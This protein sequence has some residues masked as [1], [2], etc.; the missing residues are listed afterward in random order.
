MNETIIN[1]LAQMRALMS[2]GGVQAVIVPQADP[3]QGEYLAPHW[4]VRR[5]LSGFTGS[6][7][8]LVV[9]SD[10]A[11]LWTDS[12]YFI[13]AAAQLEGTG[14]ELMKDGLAETLS[15]AEFLCSE[16]T[17]GD[18]AALDGMLFTEASV[19]AL[20]SRLD[21]AGIGLV[22]DF[23][24]IDRI[25]LDRPALP[26]G[27][28]FVHDIKY[29]GCETVKKIADILA[30]AEKK[31]AQGVFVAML[32]EV[33]WILNI[34][35][36]DVNHTPVATAF[37]YLSAGSS[38]LFIDS[39]KLTTETQEYLASQGVSTRE[40][41]D[42]K[43]FLASLPQQ[44]VLVDAAHTAKELL[45]ILG[46]KAVD[47]GTS[48]A[49]VM[50][51][52]KNEVQLEGVRA[53]MLRDGVAM[54]RSLMEIENRMAK[55]VK[56]TELDIAEILRRH[57]SAGELYFD[58]SFGTIAGYG[59]H[60]AIV[61]YEA[62]EVSSST[63]EPHGL[64]LIDSGAQYL[65]GT[66]DITRTIA[67]GEPTAQERADFTLVM[68]GHIAIAT[69]VFPFGTRGAQLDALARQFL[70]KHGLSYLHGTGH[71]VGHFLSVHEGPH[72]IRLN[73]VEAPLRPG[74]ITSNE[75]GVYRE[76]IHGIRCEN[77]VLCRHE[78]TTDFGDFLG[79]ETLTLCPFDRSL[80]DL[81]MMTEEE[82]AWVDS[83]HAGVAQMLMP[84]LATKEERAWLEEHTKPLKD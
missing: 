53:A 7:G 44:R 26:A 82:I 47:G 24:V 57:R 67:L 35:C 51:S 41:V 1:R 66:T 55:G 36:N 16:L 65:D 13:Q 78:M 83:Y 71:G 56:T 68:K 27:K 15:I 76:N 84:A 22:T 19:E 33:A 4:Q 30:D 28:I 8:D 32:D 11:A 43:S 64:L 60:G 52:V 14:I 37:L 34:R 58:E 74:S 48:A 50:K 45:D 20:R 81:S 49:S 80:F 75:P 70:W 25:W 69:A 54:V 23:D 61:H 9:T 31:D 62:D 42:V 10:K 79:F 12:R 5:W 63:L 29:S 21:A 73:N 40:Y 39:A 18:K 17:A 6:A 77:L 72:S 38:V 2:E 3:H 59:P 46:D